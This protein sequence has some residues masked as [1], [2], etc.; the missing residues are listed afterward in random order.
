MS[1]SAAN[2][3]EEDLNQYFYK[4]FQISDVNKDGTLQVGELEAT[5]R[6]TTWISIVKTTMAIGCCSFDFRPRMT[7]LTMFT[8]GPVAQ[9]QP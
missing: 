6:M 3:S 2:Y 4:L 7:W 8:V 5:T 1:L 9:L